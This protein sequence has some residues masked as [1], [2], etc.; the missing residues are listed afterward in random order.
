M[1]PLLLRFCKTTIPCSYP[2][3]THRQGRCWANSKPWIGAWVV[4][5]L[6]SIP[7][8]LHYPG[9]EQDQL[10]TALISMSS[11]CNPDHG[12]PNGLCWY[13]TDPYSIRAHR[14]RHGGRQHGPR[15]HCGSG[16]CT[17]PHYQ[18]IS[19]CHGVSSST[20]LDGAQ[21]IPLYFLSHLSTTQVFIRVS[22]AKPVSFGCLEPCDCIAL[23]TNFI[24]IKI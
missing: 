9:E 15:Q 24:L 10:S 22:L 2:P 8:L 13:Q 7:A 14:F 19:Y 17:G 20:F 18:A 1:K 23:G 4:A 6:V 3:A 16:D 12:H 5:E 21:T 11:D